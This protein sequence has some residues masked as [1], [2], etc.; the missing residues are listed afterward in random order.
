[1]KKFKIDSKNSKNVQ[2]ENGAIAQSKTIKIE[3]ISKPKNQVASMKT[4][5]SQVIVRLTHEQIAER[6]RSIWERNGC[7]SGEDDRNWVEAEKQLEVE[8]GVN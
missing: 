5:S 3:E 1:M 6:A 7:K 4:N 8:L 2:P